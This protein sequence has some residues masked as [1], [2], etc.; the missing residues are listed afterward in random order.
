[1]SSPGSRLRYPD[2][3]TVQSPPGARSSDPAAVPGSVMVPPGMDRLN[4]HPR[5]PVRLGWR[6]RHDVIV[7]LAK[8][9]HELLRWWGTVSFDERRDP[10]E[11]VLQP[12]RRT[13]QEE[14]HRLLA[15]VRERVEGA[16]RDEEEAPGVQLRAVVDQVA[17]EPALEHVE[18]L[19]RAA[20]HM[21]R[22]PR[23]RRRQIELRHPQTA[24][25]IVAGRL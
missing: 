3:V 8:L 19:D 14:F 2:S 24:A 10:R 9:L 16:R 7:A 18:E 12:T 15:R 4:S 13:D 20:V 1:M 22:G 6:R 17:A 21:W 11:I 5:G 25:R 23:E